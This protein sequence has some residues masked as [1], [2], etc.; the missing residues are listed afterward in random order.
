MCDPMTGLCPA[1]CGDGV[2]EA[3]EQCDPG[4]TSA[5]TDSRRV[6]NNCC[7][8]MTCQFMPAGTGCGS[9]AQCNEC[10]AGGGCV[11]VSGSCNDGLQCTTNDTCSDGT[12]VGQPIDCTN[13]DICVTGSCTEGP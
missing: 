11:A 2:V 13:G 1:V 7:N 4:S 12:C 6:A 10:N 9:N 3:G 8:A 5:P